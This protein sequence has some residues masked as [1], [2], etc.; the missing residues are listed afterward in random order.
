MPD[1]DKST[2]QHEID[3][4]TLTRTQL[5]ERYALTYS[6]WR[7]MK[8]RG[9]D[10]GAII[11]PEFEDF[12]DFLIAVGPRPEGHSIDRIDHSNPE[13]GLGLVR[14]MDDKG[15]ANNRSTTI[16]LTVDGETKPLSLWAEAT[17]QKA[18]TLRARLAKGWTHAEVVHGKA[19][20]QKSYSDPWNYRPWPNAKYQ[21]WED[22]YQARGAVGQ[23]PIVFFV[24]WLQNSISGDLDYLAE[25]DGIPSMAEECLAR[26]KRI[27][28][29]LERLEEALI[30]RQEIDNAIKRS[31]KP[32][33]W[34]GPRRFRQ[35]S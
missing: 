32:H 24:E 21:R 14:W 22:L 34:C 6:S 17:G 29:F 30:D 12:V 13:Y 33:G 7:N 10:E 3:A 2:P 8:Q 26:S 18:D 9:K 5:R 4:R 19:S 27:E 31:P 35:S 23:L 25:N 28:P 20:P 16:L 15:Q 1:H 11:S